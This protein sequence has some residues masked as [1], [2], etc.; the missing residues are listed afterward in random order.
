MNRVVRFGLYFVMPLIWMVL[1]LG[2]LYSP[3]TD[4]LL[5]RYRRS[6]SIFVWSDIVD[7]DIISQFEAKTG[8]KVYVNYYEGNDEMLTKLQFAGGA[9]Y[10]LIMPSHYIVRP[11][12]KRGFLKKID[13]KRLDFWNDIDPHLTGYYFD[14]NNDYSIPYVWDF[15]GLGID[16]EFF[17]DKEID[18]SWQMLFDPKYK[19]RVGMTDEP[20]EVVSI[21][22]QYLFGTMDKLKAGQ[23]TR[24]KKL[25]LRQRKFVEAYT[26]LTLDFL[27]TSKSCPVV[28]MPT[29]SLYRARRRVDWAGFVLPKE[30][31]VIAMENF[32]ITAKSKKE[33]MVYEFLNYVFEKKN[34]KQIYDLYGYLPPFKSILH[35]LDL[36]YLGVDLRHFFG[37]YYKKVSLIKTL[38]PRKQ[39]YAL[40]LS[41]KA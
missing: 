12:I 7:P 22:S 29:T 10:D 20:R 39:L 14:A 34:M 18:D 24:I 26:D 32:V 9:G 38:L 15:Y 3:Y 36:S 4:L 5:S 35:K 1:I 31:S 8:I 25:L 33:D 41:I 30:G 11:L 37:D 2:F 19:Y 40:W 16:R 28:F 6:I 13:K 21:A 23:P 17:A 27:L